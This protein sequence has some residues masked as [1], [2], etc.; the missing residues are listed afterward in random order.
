MVTKFHEKEDSSDMVV[1]RDL[2]NGDQIK[3]LDEEK[4]EAVCTVVSIFESGRGQFYG[5]YTAGHYVYDKEDGTIVTHDK[6][7]EMTTDD[8]YDVITDC[9]LGVDESGVGFTGISR[10]LCKGK[11]SK[12][13]WKDYINLHRGLLRL[14]VATGIHD[15]SAFRSV[16]KARKH[17]GGVCNA[18]IKCIKA[19]GKKNEGRKCRALERK[20]KVFYDKVLTKKAKRSIA[21]KIKATVTAAGAS[22]PEVG[23]GAITNVVARGLFQ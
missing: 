2:K 6:E 9:P 14:I 10:N 23:D 19:S 12:L 5:N 15:Y 20:S 7:G 8:M 13:S 11:M 4:E 17:L 3:G 16:G 21:K 22:F 18:M 1:V